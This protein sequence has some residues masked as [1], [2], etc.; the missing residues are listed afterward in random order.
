MFPRSE[1]ICETRHGY[2][3]KVDIRDGIPDAR[4]LGTE[5]S[6][7]HASAYSSPKSSYYESRSQHFAAK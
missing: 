1:Y 3:R 4:G 2:F 6:G 7:S 5:T